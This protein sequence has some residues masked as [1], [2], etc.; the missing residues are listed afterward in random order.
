M[1]RHSCKRCMRWGRWSMGRP[2][3]QPH[4]GNEMSIGVRVG[5][6]VRHGVLGVSI[7]GNGPGIA[8]GVWPGIVVCAVCIG[9]DGQWVG[10]SLSLT[11]GNDVSIGVW[12]GVGIWK[13]APLV[14]VWEAV[15]QWHAKL[16]SQVL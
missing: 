6:G 1:A 2:Q 12:I 8:S 14:G 15:G 5:V 13:D 9:V 10:L 4:V 16:G 3:P 11:F 7:W